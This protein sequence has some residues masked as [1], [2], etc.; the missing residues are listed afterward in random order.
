MSDRF[1]DRPVPRGLLLG[2]GA[3]VVLTLVS[4]AGSRLAGTGPLPSPATA[5]APAAVRELRFEDRPDGAVA[6][7]EA[8]SGRVVDVVAPGTNGFVR[9]VMRG[10]ARERRSH[11]VGAAPPFRLTLWEAGNLS[12]EDPTTGRRVELDAFGPTNRQ[13]FERFLT[14]NAGAAS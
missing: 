11:E 4:T 8:E 5:A 2:A 12:L 9:G 3:L 10:F 13:A 1:V 14:A 6:V 7:Y